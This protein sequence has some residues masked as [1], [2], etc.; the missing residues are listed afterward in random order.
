MPMESPRPVP[1]LMA[2]G[3]AANATNVKTG[4]PAC[5]I[6]VGIHAGAET[7]A[8]S[9]P[10]LLGRHARCIGCRNV[11]PSDAPSSLSLPF[12][13]YHPEQDFDA[14]YCGCFGWD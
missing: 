10:D 8:A 4:Q 2:C 3:H 13:Q 11:T 9:P 5:A 6:C 12:F 7:V 14:F 1:P